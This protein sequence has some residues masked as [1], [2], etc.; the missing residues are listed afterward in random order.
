LLSKIHKTFNF[1]LKLDNQI[2]DSHKVFFV[3]KK[4]LFTGKSKKSYLSV[5]KLNVE[6]F[7]A[8]EQ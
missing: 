8:K 5:K 4:K 6:R 7:S 3:A 1:I 2:K